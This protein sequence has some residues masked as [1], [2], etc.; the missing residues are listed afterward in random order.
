[1][2]ADRARNDTVR[3]QLPPDLVAEMSRL[4]TARTD[5]FY[6]VEQWKP[7]FF[8]RIAQLLTGKRR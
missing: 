8:G 7:S 6:R 4:S 3:L 5:D 1:M 2:H